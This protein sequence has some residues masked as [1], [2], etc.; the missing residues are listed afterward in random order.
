[1]WLSNGGNQTHENAEQ[2]KNNERTQYTML[3]QQLGWVE[4]NRAHILHYKL[5]VPIAVVEGRKFR[6]ISD[7]TE[8]CCFVWNKV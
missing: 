6:L 2:P 5:C 7:Y 8:R 4:E 1:M 3:L